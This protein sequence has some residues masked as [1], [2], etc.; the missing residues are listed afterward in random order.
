VVN[1]A[2]PNGVGPGPLLKKAR[3]ARD[4]TQQ[5]VSDS[6][7]LMVRVID[8]IESERWTQLPPPAFSRGYLRAYAKLLALDPDTIVKSFDAGVGHA[9]TSQDPVRMNAMPPAKG[10]VAELMQK[11]P[12]TVLT[13][14]VALVICGV[15]VVLWAVWPDVSGKLESHRKGA[16]KQPVDAVSQTGPK[17]GLESATRAIPDAAIDKAATQS[18]PPTTSTNSKAPGTA[19]MSAA[20]APTEHGAVEQAAK[21][22]AEPG[23]HHRITEVGDD[24]L[25]FTF[26][27]D[28]WVEVKDR[29]G[30]N[31]YSDLSRSGESLEL[32]GQAP[33]MIMLGYAPGVTLSFNGERV[34]LT[35]HTRN[36]VAMLALGQ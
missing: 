27:Q 32:V 23:G 11:Q 29:Q 7:N 26:T 20:P 15:V 10:G 19:Q 31:I 30:R 21:L 22:A 28:C 35:P 4:M 1:E 24:R 33:F 16:T 25:A 13:G 12:G 34:T 6:L 14:A 5:D 17:A 36:N 18:A 8:D 2:Q 9:G 3:E